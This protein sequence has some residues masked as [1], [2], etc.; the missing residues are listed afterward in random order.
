MDCLLAEAD[1]KVADDGGNA[2]NA[3]EQQRAQRKT[4]EES[5]L[6][7]W[8]NSSLFD[9]DCKEV[10]NDPCD[11]VNKPE[12]CDSTEPVQTSDPQKTWYA[13]NVVLDAGADTVRQVTS[14]Q[15]LSAA[16]F[17]A[18]HVRITASP[19]KWILHEKT[20]TDPRN[21]VWTLQLKGN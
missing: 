5:L 10:N 21:L 13:N 20:S 2:D 3:E 18:R 19:A 15:P 9:V 6:F 16:W 1:A 7:A 8:K 14:D 4:L 11:T 12:S 17:A